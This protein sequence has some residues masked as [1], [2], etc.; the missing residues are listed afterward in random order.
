MADLAATLALDWKHGKRYVPETLYK[1]V[2][3]RGKILPDNVL[4]RPISPNETLSGTSS[5]PDALCLMKIA[6]EHY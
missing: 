5:D 1:S 2:V 6:I 3:S 4:R